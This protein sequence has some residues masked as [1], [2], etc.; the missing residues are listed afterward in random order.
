MQISQDESKKGK[1]QQRIAQP[2]FISVKAQLQ[3]A[4]KNE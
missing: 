1:T 4:Q 2:K 3:I